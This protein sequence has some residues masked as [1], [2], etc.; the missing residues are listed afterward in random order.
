MS[1]DAEI[2]SW[3]A[4]LAR[5]KSVKACSN[6]GLGAAR[7]S[8]WSLRSGM[9]SGVLGDSALG[10]AGERASGGVEGVVPGGLE[11]EGVGEGGA[12]EI[13]GWISS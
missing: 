7:F 6:A 11:D 2:R 10:R 9:L 13:T 8:L 5:A 4:A 12:G 1:I 3:V